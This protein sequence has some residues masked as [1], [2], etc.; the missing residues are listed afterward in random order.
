MLMLSKKRNNP[1]PVQIDFCYRLG[2]FC[3]KVGPFWTRAVFVIGAVLTGNPE[4]AI[5]VTRDFVE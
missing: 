4:T 1:G 5:V 3:P 2:P